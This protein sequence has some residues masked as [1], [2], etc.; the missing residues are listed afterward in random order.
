MRILLVEDEPGVALVIADLLGAEGYSVEVVHDGNAG[1]EK[2]M[3]E[4]F[5]LLILDVMLPGMGGFELC[6]YVR[7]H[8]YGGAILMLTARGRVGDRV[9]G[10]RIGADDYL[11]KPYDPDELLARIQALLRRICRDEPAPATNVEIGDFTAD[12]TAGKFFKSGES[13]RLSGKEKELLRLF[14]RCPGKVLSRDDI[15]KEVWKDQPFI[16]MRTVDVHI[17]W[18]RQKL[19]ND[20]QSPQ[21]IVT[22]WGEGYRFDPHSPSTRGEG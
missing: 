3:A 14:L 22:V 10:L 4:A 19:E 5:D 18:L 2:A 9:H 16:T 17:S 11:P 13:V 7:E 15:L 6:Q 12:F 20:P 1:M 21:Y 8:G